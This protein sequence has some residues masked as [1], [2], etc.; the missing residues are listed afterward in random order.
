MN[1]SQNKEDKESDDEDDV[2]AIQSATMQLTDRPHAFKALLERPEWLEMLLARAHNSIPPATVQRRLDALTGLLNRSDSRASLQRVFATSLRNGS[3]PWFANAEAFA[4][5]AGPALQLWFY[6]ADDTLRA[7]S[8]VPSP[9]LVEAVARRWN[10]P[11]QPDR[12]PTAGVAVPKAASLFT[13]PSVRLPLLD[14]ETWIDF[15]SEVLGLG[16]VVQDRLRNTE[17]DD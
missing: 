6:G 16:I 5:C 2:K 3:H 1:S 14:S 7:A 12:K 11:K 4:A 17:S 10:T 9:L 13:G 15:A 8:P